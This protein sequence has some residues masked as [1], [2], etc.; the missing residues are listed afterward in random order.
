MNSDGVMAISR[1]IAACKRCR[2]KKIKCSHDF[3]RCAACEKADVE[4]V[5]LDPATGRDVSRSYVVSLEQQVEQLRRQLKELSSG[6][7]DGKSDPI[8]KSEIDDNTNKKQSRSPSPPGGFSMAKTSSFVENL[9]TQGVSFSKLMVTALQFKDNRVSEDG[10]LTP[11][12]DP[13]TTSSK[14]DSSDKL[15]IALLPPKQQALSLLSLYFSQV[16]SQL[17][18]FHREMFLREYFQPIYGSIP[19]DIPFASAYSSLNES[20]LS[21]FPESESWYY[22]HTELFDKAFD[23]NPKMDVLQFSSEIDVPKKFRKALYFLNITFAVASSVWHLQ[24]D[25]EISDNFKSTALRYIDDAY[26]SSNR[27][28]VMQAMLTHTQYSLMRPCVPGV[29]YLLGSTLRMCVDLELHKEERYPSDI[30]FFEK[31]LRR[32]LFWSCY[33]LD[34]QICVYLN[35]PFG[36]PEESIDV[37]YPSLLDDSFITPESLETN[38]IPVN[39]SS[40]KYVAI[41]FFQVRQL[42]AELQSILHERKE[43]PRRFENFKEWLADISLRLDSWINNVPE[44]YAQ[45]NCDFNMEFFDL[46]YNH[47]RVMIHGLSPVRFDFS[48]N[49]MI[50]LAEASMGMILSFFSLW[51]KRSLNHTW[52]ATQNVFMAGTSYLYAVFHN[53]RL[54]KQIEFDHLKRISDC[55][56]VLLSSLVDKC[57]ASKECLEVYQILSRAVI[58]LIFPQTFLP[59]KSE[60]M[61]R[62][63]SEEQIR[64]LQPGGNLTANMRKLVASIPSLMSN[65]NLKKRQRSLD[66]DS[67][68]NTK[69]FN[70]SVSNESMFSPPRYDLDLDKFFEQVQKSEADI[71]K[72]TQAF[73]VNQSTNTPMYDNNQF[74]GNVGEG[75]KVYKLIHETG[76]DSIWDQYFATPFNGED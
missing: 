20:M 1:A 32:R 62:L 61:Q 5:S 29:W 75:T 23:K 58:K 9:S 13:T 55:V 14:G 43:I 40:Y 10:Q 50:E 12:I 35:R 67:S 3:P 21:D 33:S 46:N 16:N 56:E 59:I 25:E 45:I 49:D 30:T 26:S 17:P 27:L 42:Q 53:K 4:C 65:S 72:D 48:D 19:N 57:N 6:S 11:P 36:I 22:I 64:T 38:Q 8:D 18:I 73:M 44:T 31:D 52:A 2:S 54:Q 66:E 28:E 69:R 63:P 71:A 76:V 39:H 68:A 7:T 41:S 70:Y 74:V 37:Q 47:S 34:R 15:N 60:H 51:E 24:F